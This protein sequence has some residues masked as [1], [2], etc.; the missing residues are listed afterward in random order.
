MDCPHCGWN[1]KIINE[2]VDNEGYHGKFE[3]PD[4]TCE[5]T[6]RATSNLLWAYENKKIR[7]SLRIE[8]H[9]ILQSH[10]M[11]STPP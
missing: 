8:A 6:V 1:M 7:T 2:W 4:T 3:C 11:L 10:G 9:D 5:V